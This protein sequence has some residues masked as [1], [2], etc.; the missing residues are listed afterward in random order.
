MW[1]AAVV[2]SLRA[3]PASRSAWGRGSSRCSSGSRPVRMSATFRV[4]TLLRRG[5]RG[6]G[7][8]PRP[9]CGVGEAVRALAGDAVVNMHRVLARL[10]GLIDRWTP[11][12]HDG[13][14]PHSNAWPL[15]SGARL[16]RGISL[17]VH[18]AAYPDATVRHPRWHHCARNSFGISPAAQGV[19]DVCVIPI[20]PSLG[21]SGVSRK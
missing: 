8:S 4:A 19:P 10:T 5:S 20:S 6:H 21:V 2:D 12:V 1:W 7:L 3:C 14:P 18:S 13:Q 17:A 9:R 16:Y 15:R 11:V